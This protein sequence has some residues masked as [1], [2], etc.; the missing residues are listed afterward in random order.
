M[1]IVATLAVL[2]TFTATAPAMAQVNW[3][4]NQIGTNT[5]YQ[6]TDSHGGAWSGTSNQIGQST[7]SNFQGP[8]GQTRSCTSNRIG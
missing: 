1:R 6:G 3:N 4:S 7:F 5:F 2:A 8:D